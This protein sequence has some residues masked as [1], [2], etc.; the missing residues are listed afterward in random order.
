MSFVPS[1]HGDTPS[2]YAAGGSVGRQLYAARTYI[3]HRR[4]RAT[5]PIGQ[6]AGRTVRGWHVNTYCL[7]KIH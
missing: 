1:L 3:S 2:D 7:E 4:Q 5:D 6:S